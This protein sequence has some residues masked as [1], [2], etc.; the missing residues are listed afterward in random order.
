MLPS[1]NV[2]DVKCKERLIVLVESTIFA[3][4][5]SALSNKSASGSIDGHRG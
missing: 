5:P 3:P 2:F 4:V 1:N